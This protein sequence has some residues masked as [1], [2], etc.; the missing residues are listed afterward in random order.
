MKI[1]DPDLAQGQRPG[2]RVLVATQDES[3]H[4]L[5]FRPSAH[6]V[7][8][9]I[10]AHDGDEALWVLRKIQ[11]AKTQEGLV[12]VADLGLPKIDGL[13][14]CR[15]VRSQTA[16]SGIPFLMLAGGV[17]PEM[18]IRSLDAGADDFLR[19][20][21]SL[22]EF[23]SRL[24][25]LR[26]RAEREEKS[27]LYPFERVERGS[28]VIDTLRFE[29]RIDGKVVPLSHKEFQICV[30]LVSCIDRVVPYEDLL[31]SVWGE[32]YV[33][34]RENL[35]VHIHSL[36]KKLGGSLAIEAVRGFGYRM[37]DCP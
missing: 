28:F 1:S 6:S 15:F 36:K 14:L 18:C 19:R 30:V 32:H 22:R 8:R 21:F 9:I 4:R 25:A 11:S 17:D 23:D 2:G 26:R 5:L 34:G 20:P 24:G 13:A 16:L 37:K 31:R 29:V 12:V 3:L 10:P 7:G 35:K 27:S 33:V